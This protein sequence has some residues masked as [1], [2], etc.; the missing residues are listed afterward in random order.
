MRK[1][2]GYQTKLGNEKKRRLFKAGTII[3]L[4]IA[5]ALV[6]NKIL[7]EW[8]GFRKVLD[9]I[10]GAAAPIIIG[11]VIAFLL[12]PVLIFFDRLCH[13]GSG[14]HRQE[15]TV[16]CIKS[17]IDHYNDHFVP[18]S[19]HGFDLDGSAT[20]HRQYQSSYIQYG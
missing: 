5:A 11:F 10:T 20:G 6:F 3:F 17:H 15:K 2:K 14:D 13:T 1:G 19:A 7:E 18:W 9:T 8:T 16:S 4:V 12:N